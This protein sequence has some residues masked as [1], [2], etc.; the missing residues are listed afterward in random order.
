[1]ARRPGRIAFVFA[2]GSERYLTVRRLEDTAIPLPTAAWR[3]TRRSAQPTSAR[4]LIADAERMTREWLPHATTW[5]H[6]GA[7]G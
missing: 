2:G 3:R 7:D 1:M 5:R 6:P 4:Q